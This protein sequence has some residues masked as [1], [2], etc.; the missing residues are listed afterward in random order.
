M[1]LGTT[2]VGNGVRPGVVVP[3]TAWVAVA[4]AIVPVTGVVVVPGDGVAV[5]PGDGDGVCASAAA[6]KA[7]V[8]AESEVIAAIHLPLI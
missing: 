1:L 8:A 6:P 4:V 7:T 3:V 5:A 2:T